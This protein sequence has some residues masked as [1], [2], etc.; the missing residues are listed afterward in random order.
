[1]DERDGGDVLRGGEE[2]GGTDDDA[3]DAERLPRGAREQPPAVRGSAGE[4]PTQGRAAGDAWAEKNAAGGGRA[5][6]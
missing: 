5:R 2:A 3:D 4:G 1:M 6:Y